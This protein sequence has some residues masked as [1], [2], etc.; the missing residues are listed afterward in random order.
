MKRGLAD[1]KISGT[2]SLIVRGAAREV[3]D[4]DMGKPYGEF[5]SN[6]M[7]R[8]GTALI[9]L[10]RLSENLGYDV[11]GWY[12]CVKVKPDTLKAVVRIKGTNEVSLESIDQP[13]ARVPLKFAKPRIGQSSEQ[14]SNWLHVSSIRTSR[15]AW[16]RSRFGEPLQNL[17]ERRPGKSCDLSAAGSNMLAQVEITVVAKTFQH[18]KRCRHHA[19]RRAASI[20]LHWL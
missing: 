11:R 20:L 6:Q 17:P 3:A 19:F 1:L 10:L 12:R 14:K 2:T 7:L 5:R 9:A 15:F 16:K 4:F 8:H 18:Y 13:V